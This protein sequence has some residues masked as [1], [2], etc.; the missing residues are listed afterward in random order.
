[1]NDLGIDRHSGGAALTVVKSLFAF[2]V[3][4]LCV[5]GIASQLKETGRSNSEV[6]IFTGP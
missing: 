2:Q 4:G 1:M 3:S 6:H 5:S